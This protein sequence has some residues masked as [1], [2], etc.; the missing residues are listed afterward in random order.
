MFNSYFSN[1]AGESLMKTKPPRCQR[2]LVDGMPCRGNGYIDKPALFNGKNVCQKCFNNLKWK[3]NHK[4]EDGYTPKW[5]ERME[6]RRQ[7]KIWS[8]KEKERKLLKNKMKK[9]I[10]EKSINFL[11]EETD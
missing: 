11:K 1:D 7:E 5:M 3:R 9:S 6:R 10:R 8:Q 2:K 4:S